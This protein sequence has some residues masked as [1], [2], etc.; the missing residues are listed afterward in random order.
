MSALKIQSPP[1]A[2]ST[3]LMTAHACMRTMNA[4]LCDV[5]LRRGVNQEGIACE[6]NLLGPAVSLFDRIA[7]CM[8]IRDHPSILVIDWHHERFN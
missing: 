2:K 4:T 5:E 7:A 8:R 3:R 6:K 1:P